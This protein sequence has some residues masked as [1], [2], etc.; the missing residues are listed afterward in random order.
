MKDELAL[1]ILDRDWRPQR[2]LALRQGWPAVLHRLLQDEGSWVALIQ[3]RD[4]RP[5]PL[6]DWQDV[7]LTRTIARS[8]RPLEVKL[9]D[10]V[11]H[12]GDARFSFR[13]AG[14]L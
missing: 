5:S 2:L 1:A 4:D 8:L 13:A 3:W 12:S 9:A 14:L 11:I 7:R 6:P 10:H